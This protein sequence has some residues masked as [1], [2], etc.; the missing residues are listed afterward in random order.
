MLK[1]ITALG[2]YTANNLPCAAYVTSFAFDC[3][4]EIL[5]FASFNNRTNTFF[6]LPYIDY[7]EQYFF[8]P[9][10]TFFVEHLSTASY[11]K[12][13]AKSTVLQG[14]GFPL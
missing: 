10:L 6:S 2:R 12:F 14:D 9:F 8:Y 4:A 13:E 5:R 1:G 7:L 3:V 11:F